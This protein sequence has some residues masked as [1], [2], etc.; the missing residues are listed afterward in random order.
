MTDTPAQIEK[1][2]EEHIDALRQANGRGAAWW[3]ALILCFHSRYGSGKCLASF[4]TFAPKGIAPGSVVHR[5]LRTLLLAVKKNNQALQ[6]KLVQRTGD[7]RVQMQRPL[8]GK[9]LLCLTQP[10]SGTHAQALNALLACALHPVHGVES[11]RC[12]VRR[13]PFQLPMALQP[14][15]INAPATEINALINDIYAARADRAVQNRAAEFVKRI[16]LRKTSVLD[17]FGGLPDVFDE[18]QHGFVTTVPTVEAGRQIG[19]CGGAA[20]LGAGR[21][22]G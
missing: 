12:P 21:Q 2:L 22:G 10:T 15:K 11:L 6:A 20:G 14:S 9:S 19:A 7:Q 1:F 13:G 16:K 8:L 4:H 3:R 17:R 18:T 5:T